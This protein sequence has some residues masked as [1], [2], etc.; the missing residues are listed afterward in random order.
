M[1]RAAAQP[2]SPGAKVLKRYEREVH[3]R[4]LQWTIVKQTLAFLGPYKWAFMF[5]LLCHL[6]AAALDLI[7]PQLLKHAIDVDILGGDLGGLAVTVGLYV[8]TWVVFYFMAAGVHWFTRYYAEL[9]LLGMRRAVFDKIQTLDMAYFDKTPVGRLISRGHGDVSVLMGLLAGTL[10]ALLASAV[11]IIGATGLMLWMNWRMA[12]IVV[13]VTPL[14]Y[15]T[16]SM[17]RRRARPAWRRVRRDVSRLTANV[18]EMVS[19][20]RVIQAF[21]REEDNLERFDELNVINWRSNMRV[22]RYAGWYLAIVDGI[23]FCCLAALLAWGG[24]MLASGQMVTTPD[25]VSAAMTIGMLIAFYQYAQQ[26]FEPIR[27]LAP[28]YSDALHAMAAGERVFGLLGL[29]PKIKDA[30]DAVPLGRIDGQVVF[31]HV[32]FQY[33]ADRPVLHEVSFEVQ[34]GQTLAL[35]GHTGCGKT[36][37]VSLLNRFYEVNSGSIRI[38]GH[39]IR[40]VT[41]ASLHSQT[42]I[43]L[44]ENFLFDGTVMDNIKYARPDLSDEE[45]Q[46][47][48]ELLGCDEL[49]QRLAQGY[50]TQVGERGENLSAGQRQLVSIARAMV[51]SPRILMLDEATSSVDTRTELAIQYALE[52]LLEKRTCFIVA[53]RLSTVRRA[54]QIVVLDHGRVMEHGSHEQLL[55]AGGVYA[56]LHKQ[57]IKVT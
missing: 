52:K 11:T 9:A 12:L 33:V 49:F 47:T 20:V 54:D 8:A 5:G 55:A 1:T 46:R 19:G 4:P 10:P 16:S 21:N 40:Q 27:R 37:I 51:A 45:V 41:Q 2:R 25:G 50:Q 32:S 26:L 14:L 43:I 23:A 15:T 31:D 13:L 39:D 7:P 6:A 36:T 48:C 38:D 44:Q 30:P 18:A 57:F 53:H 34:P 42:G 35:V 24:W 3:M 22:A 28:L 56:E 29:D 17:F